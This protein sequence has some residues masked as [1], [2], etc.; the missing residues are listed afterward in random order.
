MKVKAGEI[1]INYELIGQGVCVIFIHGFG[2]NLAMWYQQVPVFVKQ[3]RVLTYDVRGHG[4]TETPGDAF[5]MGIFADDLY[6]LQRA[7]GIQ[8]A[9]I[10]GYSMGGR[11]GL[12]FALKHPEM[13]TGLVLANS[14]VIGPGIPLT[15]EQKG[16]VKEHWKQMVDLLKIEQIEIIADTMTERSFSPGFRD[17]QPAVFQRY[18]DIKMRNDPRY[19]LQIMQGSP[20]D[21]ANPPDLRKLKS[22]T[23]IIAGAHDDMVSVDMAHAMA[24]AIR[25]VTLAVLPT[26]HAAAIE[27]PELF[28]QAVLDFMK[29]I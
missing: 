28:N 14:W 1:E 15:G 9:C 12:Q 23:L 29:K 19:Y 5:S 25:D 22:P 17:R 6:N 10:V 18:K 21:I 26:G 11:I 27:A 3:F 2:D 16:A 8:K 13:T 24:K 7:L 20:E 4:K